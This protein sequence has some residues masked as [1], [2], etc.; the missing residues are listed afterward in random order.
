[1]NA[2][3]VTKVSSFLSDF[4]STGWCLM[5]VPHTQPSSCINGQGTKKTTQESSLRL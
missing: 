2:L 1:M 4:L 5:Q 3:I